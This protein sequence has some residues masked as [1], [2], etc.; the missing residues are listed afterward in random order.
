MKDQFAFSCIECRSIDFQR[1]K[2]DFSCVVSAITNA[3]IEGN[4]EYA[5][6]FLLESIETAIETKFIFSTFQYLYREIKGT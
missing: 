1:K 6:L 3:N 5:F 4:I 2:S